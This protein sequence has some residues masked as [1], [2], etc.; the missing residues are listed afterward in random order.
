VLS[1]LLISPKRAER[2][3]ASKH[4]EAA[5]TAEAVPATR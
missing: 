5:A 3:D 1:F 4:P 2:P